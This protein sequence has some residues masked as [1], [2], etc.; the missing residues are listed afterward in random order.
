MR[1]EHRDLLDPAAADSTDDAMV[2]RAGAKVVAAVE[3]DRPEALTR[4]RRMHIWTAESVRADRLDFRPK[5][6]LTVLVVQASPLRRADTAGPHTRVCGCK[7]WVP[8]AV[9]PGGRTRCTPM[10][11]LAE[12]AER[13]RRSVA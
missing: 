5:H 8:L 13:V 10:K 4:S 7:S 12:I 6:R 1:P 3:V 2:L 9:D 11:T